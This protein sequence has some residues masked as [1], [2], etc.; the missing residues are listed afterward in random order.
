MSQSFQKKI[1]FKTLLKSY[2]LYTKV[3]TFHISHN[4]FEKSQLFVKDITLYNSH[5]SSF[6][7]IHLLKPNKS[8]EKINYLN[9]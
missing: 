1:K 5:N 4:S 6:F 7:F 3:T 8:E 9:I 2:N